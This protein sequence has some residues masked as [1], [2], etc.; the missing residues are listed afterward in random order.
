MH[1]APTCTCVSINTS[2]CNHCL[3]LE[4]NFTASLRQCFCSDPAWLC[5]CV[6]HCRVISLDRCLCWRHWLSLEKQ[7]YSTPAATTW[8]LM[9]ELGRISACFSLSSTYLDFDLHVKA[10]RTTGAT[11]KR[12]HNAARWC[13]CTCRECARAA[14]AI[15]LNEERKYFSQSFSETARWAASLAHPN[16]VFIVSI[17]LQQTQ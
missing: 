10:V 7:Q 12:W 5:H 3:I 9:N 16:A 13:R 14:L 11:V 2:Y 1:C 4:L 15:T 6:D 8:H 17:N